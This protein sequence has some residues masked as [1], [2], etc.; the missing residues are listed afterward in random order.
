MRIP[1]YI[2]TYG[3][4][5]KGARSDPVTYL[6][7]I[8]SDK[9]EHLEDERQLDHGTRLIDF[10]VQPHE[11]TDSKLARFEM[12]RLEAQQVGFDVPNF[13]LLTKILFR[14]LQ[15]GPVVSDAPTTELSDATDPGGAQPIVRPNTVLR[16]SSRM[17]TWQHR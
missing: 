7:F 8:L 5:I 12:A 14:A 11:R 4:E 16:A 17:G 13:Q 1:P 6:M 9:L 3:V 10:V 15:M 2:T